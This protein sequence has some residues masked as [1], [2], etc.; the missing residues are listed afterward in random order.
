MKPAIR[1]ALPILAAALMAAPAHAAKDPVAKPVSSW[2]VGPAQA[3]AFDEK[4]HPEGKG[5]LMVTEFDNGMIL[6]FHA[7]SAG[8]VGMTIDTKQQTR[9]PGD[10]E[11]VGLN[12]GQ[13]SYVLD[14]VASDASTISVPL[15]KAGGGQKVVER[16]TDLGNFRVMVAQKPYYFATTGFTDGLA[17]LQEC[18]GSTMAVP[19]VVHGPGVTAGKVIYES[20]IETMKVTSSGNQTPLA[21]AMPNLVPMGYKFVLNDVDPMT[22]VSWQAGEDWT[23]VMRQALMPH[24]LKMTVKDKTVRIEKRT[25][26]S[27]PVVEDAQI[28]DENVA[29]T[30]AV[31]PE[32]V[33]AG[34]KG[35]NLGDVLEAWGL[36]AGVNVKT[37]LEGNLTLPRDVRYEGRF[38][39]AVEKMLGQF[40]GKNKPVGVYD[41]AAMVSAVAATPAIVEETRK[42][43]GRKYVPR[44]RAPR[45]TSG[46]PAPVG[47]ID[48]P[49]KQMDPIADPA[50]APKTVKKE[51]PAK[52]AAK[53]KKTKGTWDA[54]EGT[55]LRDVLEHWGK[56]AGVDIVWMA[57][58]NYPLPETVKRKG[59]F[60]DAVM[61]VLARYEG[62][63]ARPIAQL[64]RDP[65][66]G[67][68]ALIIKTKR[69]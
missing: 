8:I 3:S 1:F 35:E 45:V 56:D 5:C 19:L 27:D 33:W 68:K 60:E 49:L 10:T 51:A 61:D 62:Q 25:G 24:N 30:T 52:T 29:S 15:D 16:L 43:T 39:D 20:G 59:A 46:V 31:V 32:G 40:T 18:M 22:P 14:G 38:D 41:G 37:D 26:E 47:M 50:N 57:D 11:T 67:E 7:R 2:L 6:G 28:D 34:K 65:K 69:L 44:P 4:D 21:F 9:Q 36:M 17:R 48:A 66:T 13:D 58:E 55:S 63:G 54:M 42:D 53:A 64:N 23:E 12:I